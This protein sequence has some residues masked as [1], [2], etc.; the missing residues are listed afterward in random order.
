MRSDDWLD[1]VFYWIDAVLE[2]VCAPILKP[3]YFVG[4]PIVDRYD[5]IKARL[6]PAKPFIPEPAPEP[7]YDPT[8]WIVFPLE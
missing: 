5:R 7:E 2:F 1:S 6:F 8:T 3:L 4:D